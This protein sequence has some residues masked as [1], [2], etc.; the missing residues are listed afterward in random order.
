MNCTTLTRDKRCSGNGNLCSPTNLCICDAGW[1]ALGDFSIVE[2]IGCDNHIQVIRILSIVDACQASIFLVILAKAFISSSRGKK[3]SIPDLKTVC[4]FCFI[5][6]GISDLVLAIHKTNVEQP[7]LIGQDVFISS[8]NAAFCI[9]CFISLTLYFHIVLN[10]LTAYSRM[11]YPASHPRILQNFFSLRVSS[12]VNLLFALPT[13]LSGI[14][15]TYHQKYATTFARIHFLAIGFVVFVY[16][17]LLTTALNFLLKELAPSDD[18]EVQKLRKKIKFAYYGA[19]SLILGGSS[20][21]ALFGTWDL[22]LQ[23]S[24]YVIVLIRIIGIPSF[25][26]LYMTISVTSLERVTFLSRLDVRFLQQG[27]IRPVELYTGDKRVPATSQLYDSTTP[28]RQILS[29]EQ[30]HR[31][32][33]VWIILTIDVSTVDLLL[34]SAIVVIHSLRQ[35]LRECGPLR[36]GNT[37]GRCFLALETMISGHQID[38]IIS[39]K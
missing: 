12:T 2:G 33:R 15:S 39:L 21:L 30:I 4:Y 13:G 25:S 6:F 5:L 28:G 36:H 34:H 10:F 9:S 19:G 3:S 27:K 35:L 8:V 31:I 20:I 24:A 1:T 18:N 37:T 23:K 32:S 11:K 22:L 14:L 7:R 38:I 26:I 16:G 17:I 29:R